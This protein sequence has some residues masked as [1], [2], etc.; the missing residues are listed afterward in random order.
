VHKAFHAAEIS[1]FKTVATDATPDLS[2]SSVRLWYQSGSWIDQ[3]D[4]FLGDGASW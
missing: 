2:Q 1:A 3:T 4:N